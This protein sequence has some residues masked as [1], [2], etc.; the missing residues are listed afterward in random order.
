MAVAKKTH[1]NILSNKKNK[2]RCALISCAVHYLSL[3]R[4]EGEFVKCMHPVGK[5]VIR[6]GDAEFK[7]SRPCNSR[8]VVIAG[9]PERNEICSFGSGVSGHSLLGGKCFSL[10]LGSILGR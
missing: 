9:L 4:K 1:P 3:Q 7:E 5:P 8:G 6:T 10:R 2:K